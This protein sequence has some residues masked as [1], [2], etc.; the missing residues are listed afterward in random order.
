MKSDR[1]PLEVLEQKTAELL[2]HRRPWPIRALNRTRSD[3]SFTLRSFMGEAA[4]RALDRKRRRLRRAENDHQRTSTSEKMMDT[5]DKSGSPSAPESTGATSPMPG[6][7][8]NWSWYRRPRAAALD[9]P[10]SREKTST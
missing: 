10:G 5:S 4:V 3:R 1:R 9:R 2:E 6:T 7:T 8:T